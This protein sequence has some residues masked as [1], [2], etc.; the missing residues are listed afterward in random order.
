MNFLMEG[1][2]LSLKEFMVIFKGIS[3]EDWF[4]KIVFYCSEFVFEEFYLLCLLFIFVYEY[5]QGLGCRLKLLL[6]F[7]A[8][9]L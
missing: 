6:A 4:V 5:F 1:L 3:L 9:F 8:L 7:S 2:V